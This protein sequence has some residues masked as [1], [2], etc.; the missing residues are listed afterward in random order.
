[1]EKCVFPVGRAQTGSTSATATGV[2]T[3]IRTLKRLLEKT[4]QADQG[5]KNGKSR[6]GGGPE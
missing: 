3:S 5:V 2:N 6:V 4:L 1:M